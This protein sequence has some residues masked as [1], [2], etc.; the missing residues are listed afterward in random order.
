MRVVLLVEDSETIRFL[1]RDALERRGFRVISVE[2]GRDAVGVA[3]DE[4]PSVVIVNKML[5]GS[6]GYEV[7][8]ELRSDP[9]TAGMKVMMLTE[10]KRREDVVRSIESGADDY[11]VKPF[12]PEDVAARVEGMVRRLQ[13][14]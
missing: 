12:D 8:R 2:H 14:Q 10:S 6:D 1:L 5:P 9:L 7:L 3:R 11:V 4:L 13:T